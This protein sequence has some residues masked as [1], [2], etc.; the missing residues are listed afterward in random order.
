MAADH[1]V[2]NEGRESR[3]KSPIRS[4]GT[5]SCHSLDAIFSVQNKNISGDGK[6]F[7]KVSRAV[8]K[9]VSHLH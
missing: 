2:L 4:R 6:E 7:T 3:D 5:R 9:A 8:G 1:K